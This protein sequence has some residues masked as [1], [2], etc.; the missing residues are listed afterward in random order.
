MTI[1]YC[2]GEETLRLRNKPTVA[3]AAEQMERTGTVFNL[4][5]RNAQDKE[6]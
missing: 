1:R 4:N 5:Q 3:K 2:I 6:Q